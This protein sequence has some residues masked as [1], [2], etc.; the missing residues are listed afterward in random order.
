M[1]EAEF[2]FSQII[3]CDRASL[4]LNRDMHL[5]TRDAGF[6]SSALKRRFLGEPIQYILG[7]ADFMGIEFK[8]TPSVLIPRPETE[9]LVET[10]VKLLPSAFSGDILDIGTGSGCIAVSLARAFPGASIKAVDISFEALQVA[11]ANAVSNHLQ[12]QIEF[13][14]NDLFPPR[15]HSPGKYD[16]IISNPPYIISQEI[17]GLQIEVRKEPRLALDGGIDGL[18]FYRRIIEGSLNYLNGS[19]LLIME[20]GFNQAKAIKN[21]FQKSRNFEIIEAVRD[22]SGIERVIAARLIKSKR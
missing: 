17:D 18:D 3:G 1:T 22:Y 4:Y 10:A 15:H 11:K 14:H 16:L 9:I 5:N 13:I 20:M 8:V 6:V 21:S 19:G 2:L 12:A 7:V